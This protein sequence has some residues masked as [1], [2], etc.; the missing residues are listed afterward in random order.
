MPFSLLLWWD[1]NRRHL[2]G[3]PNTLTTRGPT[4]TQTPHTQ[5]AIE[6]L[7]ASVST[8]HTAQHASGQG[9]RLAHKVIKYTQLNHKLTWHGLNELFPVLYILE[10]DDKHLSLIWSSLV[11]KGAW[12][13]TNTCT[14][15]HRSTGS[16]AT[17]HI[18]YG[19]TACTNTHM[20]D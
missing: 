11:A 20:P 16:Q 18:A 10:V 7:V 5:D 3:K 14:A 8:I 15:E 19:N 6:L 4:H 12:H 13:K 1:L 2:G 17:T 9:K